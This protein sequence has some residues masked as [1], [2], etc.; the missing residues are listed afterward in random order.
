M[1]RRW[2]MGIG[3]GVR[4]WVQTPSLY[5]FLILYSNQRSSIQTASSSSGIF[6]NLSELSRKISIHWISRADIIDRLWIRRRVL[7]RRGRGIKET[8]ISSFLVSVVEWGISWDSLSSGAHLY[9]RASQDWLVQYCDFMDT[10]W[11]RYL[12]SIIPS[13]ERS[14]KRESHRR[15][16]RTCDLT[17]IS[18]IL[19]T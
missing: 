6:R 17:S 7:Q 8:N 14:W 11:S 3:S 18:H 16:V 13:Q 4:A 1:M 9:P 15:Q 2:T 12:R 10:P 19:R 5:V